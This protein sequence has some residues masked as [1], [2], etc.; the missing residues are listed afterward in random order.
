MEERMK[1]MEGYL[2]SFSGR[3]VDPKDYADFVRFA[4]EKVPA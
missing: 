4:H 1:R 3:E 2:V